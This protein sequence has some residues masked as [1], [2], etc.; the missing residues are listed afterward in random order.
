MQN[1]FTAGKCLLFFF[2]QEYMKDVTFKNS[3]VTLSGI[4]K[5]TFAF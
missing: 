3:Y 1:N 2:A 4:N 5:R